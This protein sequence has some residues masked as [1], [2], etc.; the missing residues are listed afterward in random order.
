MLLL[1]VELTIGWLMLF[2]IGVMSAYIFNATNS[3]VIT[4]V[5]SISLGIVIGFFN[6][7]ITAKFRIPA[8]ITTLATMI[9]LRG[10]G[11]V[12]TGGT[13]IGVTDTGF[14]LFGSG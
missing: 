2:I 1:L 8:F 7:V 6:G 3:T 4:L 12:M 11:Y 9:M 14:T 13:P 10:G 5:A